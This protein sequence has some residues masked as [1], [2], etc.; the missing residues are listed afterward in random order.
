MAVTDVSTPTGD[1]PVEGIYYDEDALEGQ[2]AVITTHSMLKT[3]RRCPKQ[4]EFKYIHR[5]KPRMTATPLKRGTWMHELLEVFYKHLKDPVKY[6]E[7]WDVRHARLAAKYNELLDEEKDYYGDLP[8]QCAALM[9]SYLWHYVADPWE[10][11]DVEFTVETKFPNGH[12]YRGKVDMLI[13]NSL[14]LWLV[15]HKN[16]KTLPDHNFRLLDAQS[17]LYLWAARRSGYK[18]EGFIWNYLRTTPPSIPKQVK[19]GRLSKVLGDTDYLTYRAAIERMMKEGSEESDGKRLVLTQDIKDKLVQLKGQRYE[20][21]KPQTSTFFRRDILEKDNAMLRRVATENYRT[22]RTM[23]SYDFDN[24]DAVERVVDRGCTFSCSYTDLCTVD[25]MGGN[26]IP[27]LK[28][29]YRQG[30]PNDYYQDRAG[31]DTRAQK[32]EN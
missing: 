10:V 30:D 23:H 5:L 6:P 11:V 13:R 9:R 31:D 32:G 21:G 4:A 3:F 17:A 20:L 2:G 7:T 15:D 18:V 22:S 29:N 24:P 26:M 12:L 8:N 16:M 19:A 27:L 1:A 28:Q 25:L 14:G